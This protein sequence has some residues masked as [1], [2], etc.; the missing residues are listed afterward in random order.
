MAQLDEKSISLKPLKCLEDLNTEWME[1]LLALKYKKRSVNVVSWSSRVPNVREGFLSELA[2]VEL[3]VTVSGDRVEQ[4]NLVFK[5]LPQEEDK[6]D[7]VTGSF[8]AQ[9][10]VCFNHFFN[11]CVITDDF[12]KK[13]IK[14]PLPE[15]YFA[16][17]T[18]DA[19]TLVLQDMSPF[20]YKMLNPSEGSNLAQTIVALQSIAV[21][22]AVGLAYVAAHGIDALSE[23]L[24]PVPCNLDFIGTLLTPNLTVL[25]DLYE[26][27]DPLIDTLEKM[28]NYVKQLINISDRNSF[29]NTLIHGDYW[30]GQILYSEDES[31]ACI[32][33]WQFGC[34]GNP[35]VDITCFLLMSSQAD[36]YRN[37]LDK[38]LQTY[39]L[40]LTSTLDIAGVPLNVKYEQLKLSVE[41][42]WMHGFMVTASSISTFLQEDKIT[43]ARTKDLMSFLQDEGYFDTF[44]ED[45][46]KE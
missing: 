15:I 11:T 7:F 19:M 17:S 20:K 33:D 31:E 6:Y 8:V 29:I 9:R 36:V 39:W 32:L 46:A 23:K 43:V 45:A 35:V 40:T 38:V 5:F 16:G 28:K 44:L 41:R 21:L 14:I 27:G 24:M 22:H 26:N 13:G 18:S 34:V 42:N 12:K 30:A 25:A 37:H 4:L 10:E 2:F 1:H 3:S